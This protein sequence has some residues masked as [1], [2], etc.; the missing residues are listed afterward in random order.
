MIKFSEK[1]V[2]KNWLKKWDRVKKS[3]TAANFG[4]QIGTL[5]LI[6]GTVGN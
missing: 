4:P 2:P 6:S 3:R 5:P 1:L